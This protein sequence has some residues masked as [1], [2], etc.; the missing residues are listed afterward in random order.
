MQFSVR[1][2]ARLVAVP[3]CVELRTQQEWQR[4]GACHHAAPRADRAQAGLRHR[5]LGAG[6][7]VPVSGRLEVAGGSCLS[8][9]TRR[10]RRV[11]AR[12]QRLQKLLPVC[13]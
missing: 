3:A 2:T 7:D 8:G 5:R 1:A 12:D 11:L 10:A 13:C 9:T 6:H 4:L